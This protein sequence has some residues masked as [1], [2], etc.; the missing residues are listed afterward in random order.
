LNGWFEKVSNI[1]RML[2]KMNEDAKEYNKKK[3][4]V[5]KGEEKN[6]KKKEEKRAKKSKRNAIP[7]WDID[8]SSESFQSNK[9]KTHVCFMAIEEEEY[10]LELEELQKAYEELY[11]KYISIKKEVKTIKKNHKEKK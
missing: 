1:F 10:N 5:F 3:T 7:A 6:K 8:D 2:G 9:E 4:L 11:I